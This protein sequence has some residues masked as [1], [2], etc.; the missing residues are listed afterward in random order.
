MANKGYFVI[1]DICGYTEY[2]VISEPDHANEILQYLFNAQI[3]AIKPPFMISDF[4]GDAMFMYVPETNFVAP[5]SMLE[6]LE[7]FYF[8]FADTLQQVQSYTDCT[9]RNM[10]KLGLKMVI[11]C[12]EY[13]FLK[14]G[15][16]EKLLGADVILP[17]RM[18]KN[19]VIE[20]TGIACYALFS[21]A[22]A[23]P[24]HLSELA[25]PLTPYSDVYEHIGTSY[26]WDNRFGLPVKSS[27][28]TTP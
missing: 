10:P 15:D 11:H 7:N 28:M 22:A 17:H 9:C 8:V 20:E 25:Y 3:E 12:G 24:L 2:L 14:I 27:N 4:H 5:Q 6:A 21:E 18:L 16:S 13:V 19:H 1:T 23:Q 26:S